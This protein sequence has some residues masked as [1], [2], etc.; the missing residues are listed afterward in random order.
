M[1]LKAATTWSKLRGGPHIFYENPTSRCKVEISGSAHW[2]AEG[3][4]GKQEEQGGM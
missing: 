4:S 2:E 1:P 3:T